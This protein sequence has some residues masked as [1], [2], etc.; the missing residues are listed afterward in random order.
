M[1]KKR[2]CIE[3]V[4]MVF[5]IMMGYLFEKTSKEEISMELDVLSS[6]SMNRDQYLIV[7][8]N[9]DRIED[10]EEFAKLLVKMC[11][12]NSFHTIK[13]STDRGYATGIHMQVYLCDNDIEE[14]KVAM[15]IDYIQ[16]E[17][18]EKYDIC[19]NPEEFELFVDGEVTN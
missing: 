8:A 6:I 13:F 3:C 12:D 1:N 2:I 10:K 4:I 11:R 7:V 15:K 16:R 18:N 9:R 19:N 5:G 14:A 17:Y